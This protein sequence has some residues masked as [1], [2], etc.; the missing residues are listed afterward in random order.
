MVA[1]SEALLAV[2]MI[3]PWFPRIP[4]EPGS[5]SSADTRP[6]PEPEGSVANCLRCLV[7]SQDVVAED[8][9]DQ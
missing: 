7:L 2:A 9:S 4:G 5:V 6:P 8:L 1:L 3:P